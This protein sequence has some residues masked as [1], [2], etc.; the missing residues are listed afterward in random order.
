M[1]AQ[2]DLKRGD[3]LVFDSGAP[4]DQEEGGTVYNIQASASRRSGPSTCV[5]LTF[6]PG[7][8]NLRRIKVI[9]MG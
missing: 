3:G 1:P 4:D 5:D 8:L 6:G 2:E 7:Q 9:T